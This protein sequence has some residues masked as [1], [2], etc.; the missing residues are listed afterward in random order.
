VRAPLALLA[1]AAGLCARA[2]APARAPAYVGQS[3][4]EALR[5]VCDVDHLAGLGA[6]ANP[7]E[8]GR[9][10]TA[11]LGE[12][13]ANPDAIELLTLAS[14]KGGREQ[15]SMFRACGA[16]EGIRACPLADSLEA[17]ETGALSP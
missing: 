14:V 16:E 11:W 6:E 1:F 2:H 17:D 9:K 4:P 15:A 5:L 3:L 8:L 10:R 7:L 12:H 13:V